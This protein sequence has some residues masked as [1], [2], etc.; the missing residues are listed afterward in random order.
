MAE[1]L[2]SCSVWIHKEL[3]HSMKNRGQ[4]HWGQLCDGTAKDHKE[5]SGWRDVADEI[6]GYRTLNILFRLKIMIC[7]KHKAKEI[8]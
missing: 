4:P 1:G 6:R 7:F 5:A 8:F 3:D 2:M